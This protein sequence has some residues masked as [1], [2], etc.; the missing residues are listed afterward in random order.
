MR[1]YVAMLGLLALAACSAAP[2][3]DGAQD[4]VP[5]EFRGASALYDFRLKRVIEDHLLDFARNPQREA[6]IFDAAQDLQDH[7]LTL[8]FPDAQVGYAIERTPALRVR[9]EIREG[10]RVTVSAL[11]LTGN[12][13]LR[14]DDLLPLWSRTRSG[15]VGSGDPYFVLGDLEALGLAIRAR[16][17]QRGYLDAQVEGPVVT[18]EQGA[19]QA[20][21]TF[22]IA[23]GPR[24][25]VAAV[26]L[27]P[28]L[29]L[30]A[31]S[32][33]LAA[34]RGKPFERDELELLRQRARMQLEAK[35]YPSPRVELRSDVD[36]ATRTASVTLSGTPGRR[37]RVASVRV[38]G[39]QRTD[40]VVFARAMRTSAGEVYDGSKVD[41]T[42]RELYATGLFRRVE[43]T[44]SFRDE[45]SED[46][47]LV[48]TVEE[49]EARGVDAMFGYGSYET[50]RGGLFFTDRNLFG[51]GHR[52]QL[53]ARASLKSQG[54]TA[55]WTVPDALGSGTA[56]T[57]SGYLRE[58][59]EPAFIDLSRGVDVALSRTLLG[60]LRGRVGYELQSRNGSATDASLRD[61][62]DDFEIGALFG[63]LVLDT[64]DSPVYP[65][66]GHRESL[67]VERARQFLGGDIELDRVIWSA[68]LFHSFAE[69]VVLGLSARGGI[70]WPLD[71]DSLPVQERF[72][73]GGE[74]T[75]RS[76]REAELGPR[77]PAG[78]PLGGAYFNTFS[79][80][81]RVPLVRA[82]H[83][84]VFAD[85]GNVGRDTDGF[86]LSKLRYGVGMGLRLV[87]PIG[88]I[89]LDGAVNP[90]RQEGEDSWALHLSVGL[91]F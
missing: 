55:S 78:A 65:S 4:A 22:T 16:Y 67:K 7:Y 52:L 21:V 82:L 15:V 25:S 83:G 81:L 75:V 6:A 64:R 48:I 39:N 41:A 61:D 54:L 85:A 34:W 27:A 53:G 3:A 56:L 71:P 86:G 80:E 77:T 14:D 10:P 69:D 13:A 90:D 47:D 17:A 29:G 5:V 43:V 33:D 42:T 24:Y 8:G 58:R 68:A 12:Q 9:F 91:P 49:I 87:L 62:A 18:R 46:L 66:R 35:G 50:L 28:D 23:E 20:E 73:N 44:R 79:A 37:A 70:A 30:D 11:R 89:R 57:V 31:A 76:F 1:A 59:E 19:A 40:L 32:L 38:E 60:D 51:R 74:S 36:R 26:Q 63:E 45:R 72:F 84:A 88:P 2:Q